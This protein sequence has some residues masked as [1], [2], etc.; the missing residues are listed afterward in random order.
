VDIGVIPLKQITA[1]QAAVRKFVDGVNQRDPALL[2]ETCT[3]ELA[4]QFSAMLPGMYERMRDHHI[5][6]VDMVTDGAAVAMHMAT[7]GYHTG[8]MHNLP[9][10]GKWWTNRVFSYFHFEGGKISQVDLLPDVENII[11]QL[12]GSIQPTAA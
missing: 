7:S 9:A 12:G 4:Q 11:K 8:T 6:I 2:A 1:N 3:P 5:E 10:T